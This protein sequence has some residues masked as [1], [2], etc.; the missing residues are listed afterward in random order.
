[1]R[2][3]EVPV[4]HVAKSLDNDHN[5]LVLVVKEEYSLKFGIPLFSCNSQYGKKVVPAD[6]FMDDYQ[7]LGI[8]KSVTLLKEEVVMVPSVRTVEHTVENQ[9]VD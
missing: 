3:S 1:M 8:I 4:G 7:D 2:L 6:E 5:Y 9:Y